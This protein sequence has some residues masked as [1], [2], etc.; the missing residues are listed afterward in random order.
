MSK[1]EFDSQMEELMGIWKGEAADSFKEQMR[2]LL[3][4]CAKQEEELERKVASDVEAIADVLDEALEDSDIEGKYG[5]FNLSPS[6]NLTLEEYKEE[7]L[8][9]KGLWQDPNGGLDPDKLQRAQELEPEIQAEYENYKE[10]RKE[11]LATVVSNLGDQ[12][13]RLASEITEGKPPTNPEIPGS[14]SYSESPNSFRNGREEPTFKET[15]PRSGGSGGGGGSTGGDYGGTTYDSP[16]SNDD[17]FA[18]WDATNSSLSGASGEGDYDHDG[19]LAGAPP[20]TGPG[21]GTPGP[22]GGSS[23]ITPGSGGPGGGP[24]AGGGGSGGGGGR[25]GGGSGG[26]GRAGGAGMQNSRAGAGQGNMRPGGPGQGMRAGGPAGQ[27]SN[28]RGGGGAG[29]GARNAQALAGDEE[30]GR[31]T[32]LVEDDFQWVDKRDDEELD[33]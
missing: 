7:Y 29:G 32:W 4:H 27:G 20:S 18:G 26:G 3:E 30:A 16:P 33:D 22:G 6:Y 24:M 17:E 15:P 19:G 13:A 10:D 2:V 25:A 23:T 8:R 12:Y 9:E 11:Q 5:E 28:M 1:D 14:D 31:E 21:M